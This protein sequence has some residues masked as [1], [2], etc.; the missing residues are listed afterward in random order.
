[1][2]KFVNFKPAWWLNH[3]HTQTLWPSLVRQRPK[4]QTRRERISLPDGD[5]IDLD[6]TMNISGPIV[7]VFHGLGG[8]IESKYALG[9]LKAIHA[10]GWRGV[11]M[12]FRSASGEVN[13]SIKSYHAGETEDT[14]YVINLLH[15]REMN[16]PI[17]VCGFSIGGSALLNLLGKKRP[18]CI[19]AAVAVSVPF[20]LSNATDSL[21]RGFS[22]IYQR[23]I[24][25]SLKKTSKQKL[26][27]VHSP[28]TRE[29]LD[30]TKNFRQF[31]D[32]V[33][34]P[35]HGFNGVD[36]YYKQ[37]S[38]RQ[39]LTH[40][41]TPTLLIHAKDDPFMTPDAIPEKRELSPSVQLELH[42]CGGHV[43]FVSGVLPWKPR[44]WLEHRIPEYL[45]PLL[46]N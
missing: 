35:V 2:T 38:S 29:K 40:I 42:N 14:G 33:T 9:L 46:S 45:T 43:G 44:Y 22:R 31:D 21:D 8:S 10:R 5:F 32:L 4:I 25:N 30:K 34:A 18:P 37:C 16:T 12:N 28:F 26:A 27:L 24:L 17:A 20:L 15:K 41:E 19:K 7:I 39:Y 11:L 36:D 23:H 6:W 13:K 1:M 3:P